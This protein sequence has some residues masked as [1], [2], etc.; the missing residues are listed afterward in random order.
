MQSGEEFVARIVEETPT[1]F[2][3]AKP[4]TLG[5]TQ[6]GIKFVPILMLADPDKNVIIPK[7]III[8]E[9]TASLEQQYESLITGI[10]LPSKSG[11][12]T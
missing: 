7:P 8:G 1:H 3:V 5:Q 6:T 12:I 4:L 11:I 2:V 10:A 9:P